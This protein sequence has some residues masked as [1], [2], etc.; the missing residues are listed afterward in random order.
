MALN[1]L[2]KSPPMVSALLSL[3]FWEGVRRTCWAKGEKRENV[4]AA[5]V[6]SVKTLDEELLLA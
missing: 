2:Q 1:T 5:S 6:S 4:D 3:P